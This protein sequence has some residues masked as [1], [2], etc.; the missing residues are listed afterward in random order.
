MWNPNFD[1]NL[2]NIKLWVDHESINV[3]VDWLPIHLWTWSTIGSLTTRSSQIATDTRTISLPLDTIGDS[4]PLP[5]L[6]TAWDIFSL[7]ANNL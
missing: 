1:A 5:T 7:V 4:T 3:E 2:D 6:Q